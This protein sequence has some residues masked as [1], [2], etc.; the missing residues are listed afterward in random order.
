MFENLLKISRQIDDR[1]YQFLMPFK[2]NWNEALAF[3]QEI[4]RHCMD[5]LAAAQKAEEEKAKQ[6]SKNVGE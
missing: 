1:H 2:G 5:Q 6:E 3:S 4:V